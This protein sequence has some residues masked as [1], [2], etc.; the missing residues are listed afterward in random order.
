M[1]NRAIQGGAS[2]LPTPQQPELR[3]FIVY[4]HLPEGCIAFPITTDDSVPHLRKG[5]IAVV[6][7]GDRE[8][9]ERELFVI[10]Y[11]RTS[12]RGPT[13]HVVELFTKQHTGSGGREFLG[14]WAGAYNRPRSREEF[15]ARAPRTG[16]VSGFV[17]GPYAHRDYPHPGD[18]QADYLPS[19]LVGR[20]VGILEPSFEEPKRISGSVAP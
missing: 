19:L 9:A 10:E 2:A 16:I 7:T 14:W 17:D 11:G 12:P 1:G 5:D 20:V 15:L 4:K 8:G 3:A 6:D 18:P 13:R